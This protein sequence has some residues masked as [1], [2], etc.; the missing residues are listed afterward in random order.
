[1]LDIQGLRK[2]YGQTEVLA[3]VETVVCN[4]HD[5][6]WAASKPWL[7]GSTTLVVLLT[8][9]VVAWGWPRAR[10]AGDLRGELVPGPLPDEVPWAP[11][12]RGGR[13]CGPVARILDAASYSVMA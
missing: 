3:G 2:R 9:T 1:M 6:V 12:E 8:C 5:V 13:Q 11:P 4:A 10:P 7:K